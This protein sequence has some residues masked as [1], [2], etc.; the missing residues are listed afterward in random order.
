MSDVQDFEYDDDDQQEQS[1][2]NPLRQRMKQLE[3]ENADKDKALAEALQAKRELNFMKAG[4]NP[5]EAKFRYF[6]K[7][8]DGDLS[9]DAIK[10]A[11]IEAQ[12][13]SPANQIPA[14]EAGAWGRTDEVAAGS[15]VNTPPPDLAT[16]IS[17]AK[18]EQEIMDILAE[19][20]AS[21]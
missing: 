18:S 13:M 1:R 5:D 4:I 17:R 8:Y 14:N 3:K 7:A 9:P 10:Q 6:V 20:Q 12:L 15:H 19:A 16:R 2:P 11:A 21:Q